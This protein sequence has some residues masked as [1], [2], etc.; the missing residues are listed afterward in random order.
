MARP[1]SPASLAVLR[2]VTFANVL[3]YFPRASALEG[4]ADIPG[5]FRRPPTGLGTVAPHLPITRPLIRGASRVTLA[6]AALAT[7]GLWTT[8]ASV[9][10][11][12]AGLYVGSIQWYFTRVGHLHHVLWFAALVAVS[13]CSDVLALDECVRRR[14][15]GRVHPLPSPAYGVPMRMGWLLLASIYFVPGVA[16][17]ATGGTR[18]IFSDNLRNRAWL[19]WHDRGRKPGPLL[20]R[21]VE[22][23]VVM[24]GA[25][26][27]TVV[28][29][30]GFVFALPSRRGRRAMTALSFLFHSG[31]WLMLDLGP[32]MS[33][34]YSHLGLHDWPAG[35]PSVDVPTIRR[36]PSKA[37]VALVAAIIVANHAMPLTGAHYGWPFTIYPIF[38][39]VADHRATLLRAEIHRVGEKPRELDVR[40][41]FQ[42]HGLSPGASGFL[43]AAALNALVENDRARVDALWRMLS[44]GAR[45]R[46]GDEAVFYADVI[47]V[48]PARR[49]DPALETTELVRRTA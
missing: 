36:S 43:A 22:N 28:F 29:E 38:H 45:L 32:F 24:Q 8:P 1:A 9:T 13:P 19:E 37:P 33:L 12:L 7:I 42:A 21:L 5:E 44:A 4:F 26:L 49:A 48:D 10:V 34:A 25:A 15:R 39:G 46:S 47:D 2:I 31:I 11:V 35:P 3:L 14:R 20:C 17:L 18:W 6:A 41:A 30:I 40:G 27:T 16:K 23:R